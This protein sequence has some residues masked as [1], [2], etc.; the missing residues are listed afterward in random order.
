MFLMMEN[1][2]GSLQ[3]FNMTRVKRVLPE[4]NGLGI[5]LFD[6]GEEVM[7]KHTPKEIQQMT[8]E[9]YRKIHAQ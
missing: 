8:T 9:E 7:V 1:Y 3:V 6:D 4:S 2:A 5:I